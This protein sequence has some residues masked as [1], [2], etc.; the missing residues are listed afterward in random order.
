VDKK[1]DLIQVR[2]G[3]ELKEDFQNKCKEMDITPSQWIRSKIRELLKSK[4]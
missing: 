3:R 2:T 1:E 4:K